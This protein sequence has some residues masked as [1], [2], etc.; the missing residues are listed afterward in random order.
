MRT[1]ERIIF[2]N[3]DIDK[4]EADVLKLCEKLIRVQPSAVYALCEQAMA[5]VLAALKRWQ[6]PLHEVSRL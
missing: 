4:R 6:V 3:D 5:V 1:W 2:A